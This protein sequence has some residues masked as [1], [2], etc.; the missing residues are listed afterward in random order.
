MSTKVGLQEAFAAFVKEVSRSE[1]H[2]YSLK[3][4][5]NDIPSLADLM[6]VSPENLQRLFAKGGL[7]RLGKDEKIFYLHASKFDSF[8]AVFMIEGDCEIRQ[9]QIKGLKT[10]QWFFR[11]GSRIYGDLYQP[12]TKGRA[13]RVQNIRVIRQCSN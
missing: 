13:P 6:E 2:W 5:H 4:L 12:G 11:L 9:L 10:K 1:A 7:G 3:P 8:R